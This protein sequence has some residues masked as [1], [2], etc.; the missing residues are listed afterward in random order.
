[1]KTRAGSQPDADLSADGRVQT[2]FLIGFMGAGKTSVGRAL[3]RRMGWQFEDLDDRIEGREKS[4]IE[5]LFRERGEAGFREAEH[6]ALRELLTEAFPSP[7]VVALGGGA[8]VQPANA[9]L[10][11]AANAAI[12]LLDAPVAELFRRCEQESR[13]RPLSRNLEEFRELY[14]SRSRAYARAS[15]RIETG[16]KEIEAVAAEIISRLELQPGQGNSVS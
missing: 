4:G 8:F 1:M 5:R 13:V 15:L 16:G 10:L 11:E 3:A 14:E 6:K 7:R 2:V 12:V 9:A